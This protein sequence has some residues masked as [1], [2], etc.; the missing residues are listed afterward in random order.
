MPGRNLIVANFKAGPNNN[1]QLPALK[2]YTAVNLS[3]QT[4]DT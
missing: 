2:D 1:T 4:H 3:A